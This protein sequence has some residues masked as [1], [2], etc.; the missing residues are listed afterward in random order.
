[1]AKYP[2]LTLSEFGDFTPNREGFSHFKFA[3]RTFIF[4]SV[5]W[6]IHVP[7]L[8]LQERRGRA[9]S[10]T[11]LIALSPMN[12]DRL[13]KHYNLDLDSLFAGTNSRT[14][15]ASGP[16]PPMPQLSTTDGKQNSLSVSWPSTTNSSQMNHRP[17]SPM[18][19]RMP[20][21]A[22][23]ALPSV[24]PRSIPSSQG[25][26]FAD[27]EGIFSMTNSTWAEPSLPMPTTMAPGRPLPPPVPARNTTYSTRNTTHSA[28]RNSLQI[29]RSSTPTTDLLDLR[30]GVTLPEV[31]VS[32]LQFYSQ[33]WW[34]MVTGLEFHLFIVYIWGG[35]Y[36]W[37]ATFTTV[38]N[39]WWIKL[40][41]S[42]KNPLTTYTE[43]IAV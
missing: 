17:S 5:F 11:N 12:K 39:I 1:M 30:E 24:P 23:A 13:N 10:A 40:I 42:T 16:H 14:A 31:G 8:L 4:C 27:L 43:I 28:T 22:A 3:T 34:C 20:N 6:D 7:F 9:D 35:Q 38:N 32:D 21:G 33:R 25:S 18:Q 26:S 41:F 15:G 19:S 36:I 2:R 29:Q 37:Y